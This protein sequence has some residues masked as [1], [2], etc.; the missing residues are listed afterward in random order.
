MMKYVIVV[1]FLNALPNA[2]LK[3]S[4]VTRMLSELEL[5]EILANTEKHY[6]F[7][8]TDG[9]LRS[10]PLYNVAYIEANPVTEWTSAY[11][12]VQS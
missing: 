4:F 1:Y 7:P 9:S 8:T 3:V 5:S 12:D 11:R 6:V 10:F 2:E